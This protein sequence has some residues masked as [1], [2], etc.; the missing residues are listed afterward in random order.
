MKK[1]LLSI[2]ALSL[3]AC[4]ASSAGLSAA[5]TTATPAEA[6]KPY[7]LNTCIVS[8]EEL[9]S[10]GKPIA[11]VHNGQ[12]VKFCCKS[13]MKK[14]DKDPEGMI[15]KMHEDAAAVKK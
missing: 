13:C 10:M 2:A 4:L 8:G 15:K 14:F 12:E 7:P 3:F 11:K 5:D 6:A 9:G 1:N